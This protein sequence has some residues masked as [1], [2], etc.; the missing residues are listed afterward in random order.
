MALR[1]SSVR[2]SRTRCHATKTIP[3]TPRVLLT[4][5]PNMLSGLTCLTSTRSFCLSLFSLQKSDGTTPQ[6]RAARAHA[7]LHYTQSENKTHIFVN[8]SFIYLHSS[9]HALLNISVEGLDC[10]TA[11]AS[12]AR[13]LAHALL[14]VTNLKKKNTFVETSLICI[15]PAL[16][17]TLYLTLTRSGSCLLGPRWYHTAAARGACARAMRL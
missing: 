2:R 13:A 16:T 11:A 5:C 8:T 14:T 10:N 1:R 7:L 3:K 17:G 9:K 12:G 4:H 6:Q 15:K